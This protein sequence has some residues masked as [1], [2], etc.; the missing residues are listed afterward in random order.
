MEKTIDNLTN[1]I[2][3]NIIDND[4]YSKRY[5]KDKEALMITIKACVKVGYLM[6]EEVLNSKYYPLISDNQRE[7]IIIN[8]LTSTVINV[9]YPYCLNSEF[10]Y[11]TIKAYEKELNIYL[12]EECLL[13]LND[14]NNLYNN[15]LNYLSDTFINII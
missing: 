11:K 12:A 5:S 6:L 10:I 4:N 1:I 7:F 13:Y 2:K 14:K 3:V 15:V 8:N 9:L